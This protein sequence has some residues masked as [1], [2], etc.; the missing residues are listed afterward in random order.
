M[1]I[2]SKLDYLSDTKDYIRQCI[3]QKGVTVPPSTTFRQYGDKILEIETGSTQPPVVDPSP[4]IQLEEV[5]ATATGQNYSVFPSSGYDG[6]SKVNVTGDPNLKPENIATGITIYGVTGTMA[7]PINMSTI[8][9]AYLDAF[10]IAKTLYTGLYKN[11]MILESDQAVAFGFMLD[12]FTVQSYDNDTT[13][14]TASQWVYVAYNKT[15]NTWKVENWTNDTSNG[16]SFIKNIRYSDTYIYY[17]TKLL[18]PFVVDETTADPPYFEISFSV[19]VKARSYSLYFVGFGEIDWGDG[20]TETVNIGEYNSAS[21]VSHS[22]SS[23]GVYVV[24]MA[25]HWKR[26][27]GLGSSHL[28]TN[29]TQFHTDL[30]KGIVGASRLLY[31]N[32]SITSL[33]PTLFRDCVELRDLASAFYGCKNVESIPIGFLSACP[34]IT[35][36]ESTF[37]NM[38]KLASIPA[39][40]LVNKYMLTSVKYMFNSA[41]LLYTIPAHLFDYA[42]NIKNFTGFVNSCESFEIIP[43]EL[44]AAGFDGANFS[45]FF[46]DNSIITDIPSGLFDNVTNPTNVSQM[47]SWCTGI[48]SNLPELWLRDDFQAAEHAEC[49][50]YCNKAPNYASVPSDWKDN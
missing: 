27:F 3:Q 1:S 49:F 17:G 24:T 50:R 35:S 40:L 19:D 6:I 9:G 48:T 30:P 45:N 44:F 18:Y 23:A 47:F 25:G 2:A 42:P 15:T 43:D 12:D 20:V 26:L 4:D 21:Y 29:L 46:Y 16:N 10:E 11:L 13:E 28:L 22:Y 14:F 5:T 7:V 8:P 36:L 31:G 37:S 38:D 41:K 33:R 39:D 34:K 32:T